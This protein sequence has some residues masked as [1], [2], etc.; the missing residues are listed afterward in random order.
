MKDDFA[1][2]LV[3][4]KA[5]NKRGAAPQQLCWS[6]QNAVPSEDG[7]RGC[8]WSTELRPVPGWDAEMVAK[9][10]FGYTWR[11][12]GCPQYV[13]DAPRMPFGGF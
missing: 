4:G 1:S 8:A 3:S 13:P 11:I 5:E 7:R 9:P 6:C 2:D 12:F 10:G